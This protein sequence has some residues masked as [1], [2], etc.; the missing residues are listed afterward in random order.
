M[1][2]RISKLLHYYCES[3]LQEGRQ[4]CRLDVEKQY[5]HGDVFSGWI[6]LVYDRI[7]YSSSSNTS[8]FIVHTV[9]YFNL[10][11]TMFLLLCKP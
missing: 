4:V 9:K 5:H 10:I 7:L 8:F 3:M 11:K 1:E 2:N 6:D